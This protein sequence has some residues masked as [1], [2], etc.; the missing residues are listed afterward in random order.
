MKKKKMRR[1][2][3]SVLLAGI[4][5][6]VQPAGYIFAAEIAEGTDEMTVTPEQE[7]SSDELISENPADVPVP[8]NIEDASVP[9]EIVVTEEDYADESALDEAVVTKEDSEADNN[10]ELFDAEDSVDCS[11]GG[12]GTADEDWLFNSMGERFKVKQG[13]S[14][15][16]NTATSLDTKKNKLTYGIENDKSGGMITVTSTG[17]VKV[18]KKA[19]VGSTATVA[20]YCAGYVARNTVIVAPADDET[21]RFTLDPV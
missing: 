20:A 10:I 12:E 11:G 15:A 4:L 9:D 2:I 5:T 13:K 17:V 18:N 21:P 3:L 8:E 1:I 19:V 16:L 7:E 14:V 6:V